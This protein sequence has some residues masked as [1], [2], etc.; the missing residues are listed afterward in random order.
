MQTTTTA[1]LNKS[2]H[3]KVELIRVDESYTTSINSE[4]NTINICATEQQLDEI[5]EIITKG[6]YD[7]KSYEDLMD[8]LDEK[9]RKIEELETELEQ[10]KER[11][12]YE[13]LHGT[14]MWQ[15]GELY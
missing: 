10:C 8:E 6:F 9:D 5:L 13:R 7:G 2:E 4:G 15:C 3:I 1:Y 11:I 14:S 12:E